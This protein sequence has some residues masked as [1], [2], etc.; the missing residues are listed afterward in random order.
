MLDVELNENLRRK[1]NELEG[2]LETLDDA[3]L[4]GASD[5]SSMEVHARE[6]KTLEASIGKLSKELQGEDQWLIMLASL[7]TNLTRGGRKDRKTLQ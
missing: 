1:R 3:P 5:A 2:M 4:G 7:L 6:L